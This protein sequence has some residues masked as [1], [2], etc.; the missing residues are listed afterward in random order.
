MI[1]KILISPYA[2]I[3]A[4][5][6]ILFLP[7]LG[8]VHLFDWDEINF[9]ESAR[10]MLITGDYGR[11]TINFQ[12]FWEK[13]PLFIWMQALSM[14]VFGINEYAA[15]LPNA[16]CGIATLLALF[17]YGRRYRSTAFGWF[18]VLVY[19]G[20]WLPHVYFKSGIIDP[21][22]NL[23]MFLGV[24]HLAQWGEAL[25][26]NQRFKHATLAGLF[27]GLA[28][29][30]KGPVGLLLP[31]ITA[32]VFMV[33]KRRWFLQPM[34]LLAATIVFLATTFAWYGVET[35]RNGW[36]FL[37]EF[38]EYNLR[39]AQTEDSGHGGFLFYHFV[40]LL[41]GCF[42]ASIL[43]FYKP[44]QTAV[45]TENA[46][47]YLQNIHVW[48]WILLGV[49]LIVF[50]IVQTKII[51]YSSFA[52]FPITFLAANTLYRW[53]ELEVKVPRALVVTLGVGTIVFAIALI[54]GTYYLSTAAGWA[55]IKGA[56]NQT[57]TVDN[58]HPWP[59]YFVLVGLLYAAG[60]LSGVW[61]MWKG[62]LMAGAARVL[63]ITAVTVQLVCIII[64]PSVEPLSQGAMVTFLKEQSKNDVYLNVIGFKSYAQ[65]YYGAKQPEDLSSKEFE[66]VLMQYKLDHNR[67]T[68]PPADFNL[69]EYGWHLN[70]NIDKPVLFVARARKSEKIK[71][72]HPQLKQI[73]SS[74]GFVFFRR[75]PF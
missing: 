38:I 11:V 43:L 14:K 37:G 57:E 74:G 33:V 40:V 30:T 50:T 53:N 65:Y 20:T 52:Y 21:V 2:L 16:L 67:T 42:P 41:A 58:T 15:R 19:A 69:L 62:E 35:M 26:Q 63:I 28:V 45:A 36:W 4:L 47:P 39:L 70:G 10:E 34:P 54:G 23:F 64:L 56:I 6:A 25:A 13:P 71:S 22:F 73:G 17:H 44:K 7:M 68:I 24:I 31:A 32:V 5:G 1:K 60:A 27:V 46:N 8:V 75:E 72:Q 59:L 61:N 9:A 12:P 66:K 55:T 48:M 3:I 49:V 18:W 51:H 29:L